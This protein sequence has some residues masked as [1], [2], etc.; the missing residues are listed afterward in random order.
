LSAIAATSLPESTATALFA[1]DDAVMDG[2]STG[3]FANATSKAIM[4]TVCRIITTAQYYNISI[5]ATSFD[6]SDYADIVLRVS[7]V[8]V[9]MNSLIKLIHWLYEFI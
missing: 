3:S 6:S 7:W 2:K 8:L 1:A 4:P 5:G 9:S